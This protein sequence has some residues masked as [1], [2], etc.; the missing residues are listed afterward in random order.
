MKIQ[1]TQSYV[2]FGMALKMTILK[3]LLL[4]ALQQGSRNTDR[5]SIYKI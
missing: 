3:V 5:C 1:L 4:K 2:K